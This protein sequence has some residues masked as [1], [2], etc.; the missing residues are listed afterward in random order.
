MPPAQRPQAGYSR[1]ERLQPA[2]PNVAGLCPI[3]HSFPGCKHK[4]LVNRDIIWCWGAFTVA[5]G[6]LENMMEGGNHLVP[7]F[8]LSGGDL[9]MC[10]MMSVVM[11]V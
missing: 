8:K 7:L 6:N 4:Q 11:L 9:R 3:F 2:A 5:V 1:H 10:I